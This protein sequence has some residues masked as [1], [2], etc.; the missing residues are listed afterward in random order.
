MWK[1]E[2]RQWPSRHS[3]LPEEAD[4]RAVPLPAPGDVHPVALRLPG[5]AATFQVGLGVADDLAAYRRTRGTA[6]GRG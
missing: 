4:P 3:R 5:Q 6:P 2:D 1:R